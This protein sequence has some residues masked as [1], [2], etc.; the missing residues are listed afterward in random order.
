MKIRTDFVT[1]SSSSSYVVEICV[2]DVDGNEYTVKLPKDEGDGNF[3]VNLNCTAEEII[4]AGSIDEL[5]AMLSEGIVDVSNNMYRVEHI[6]CTRSPRELAMSKSISELVEQLE[7]GIDFECVSSRGEYEYNENFEIGD[8]RE[9][10]EFIEEIKSIKS[11][12]EIQSIT[13]KGS[14]NFTPWAESYIYTYH[15]PIKKYIRA[16]ESDDIPEGVK[17]RGKLMFS[18]EEMAEDA[19]TTEDIVVL[20]VGKA[21]ED[22]LWKWCEIEGKTQIISRIE[23]KK[24]YLTGNKH[25]KEFWEMITP[26]GGIL[27]DDLNDNVDFLVVCAGTDMN[28]QDVIKAMKLNRKRKKINAIKELDLCKFLTKYV[29]LSGVYSQGLY[30]N[31][32]MMDKTYLK[33]VQSPVNGKRVALC[34]RMKNSSRDRIKEILNELGAVVS[35]RI[36]S[37]TAYLIVGNNPGEMALAKAKEM[38]IRIIPEEMF[39]EFVFG[40]S[41]D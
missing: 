25:K 24:F 14:E 15:L 33:A 5:I 31:D 4:S 41:E 26:F 13:I 10:D 8:F 23:D 7:V 36:T 12:D 35:S 28:D 34:G 39:D 2:E 38:K 3:S 18:D 40:M 1:N 32:E 27:L 22:T 29:F 20:A 30:L 16:V 19:L 17:R 37:K 21:T 9:G 6:T 11:M